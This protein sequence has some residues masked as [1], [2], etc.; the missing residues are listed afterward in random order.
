MLYQ[1]FSRVFRHGWYVVGAALVALLVVSAAALLPNTAVLVQVLGSDAVLLSTKLTFLLSL[2]GS[3][4]TNYSLLSAALLLVTAL[5]FGVNVALLTYYIKRRRRV[6]GDA[7][8]KLAGVGGTVS[9]LFGIGC[10]ACGSVVLTSVLGL[11]G[12]SGLL[13]MLP[14]HGAEFALLG[15]VLLTIATYYLA[16]R[17]ADPLV[18][19]SA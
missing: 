12:A 3:L 16:K 10:A 14:Y 11:F 8:A 19:P 17:I 15:I 7:A 4:L 1:S 13:L 6:S 18:C 5:L 9:A 2:Y